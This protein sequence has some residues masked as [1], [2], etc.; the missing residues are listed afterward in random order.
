MTGSNM[1]MRRYHYTIHYPKNIKDMVMEFIDQFRENE[2]TKDPEPT[3]HAAEQLLEDKRALKYKSDIPLPTFDE[4]F[5]HRN[6][7]VEFY[8]N[9]DA[10]N[11]QKA[12]I[13]V[14]HL[15]ENLDFT[16]VVAREGFIVSA[17]A[18]EK[19]DVH[20]LTHDNNYYRPR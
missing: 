9:L 4:I 3:Y 17:W 12:V 16:Y 2:E 13:R 1:N 15:H 8:E 7:L 6:T 5:D 19:D 11:I 20:R 14:Y 10:K 18:N